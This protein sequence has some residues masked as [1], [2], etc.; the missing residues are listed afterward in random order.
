[1]YAYKDT[2]GYRIC[3]VR[4]GDKVV[5]LTVALAVEAADVGIPRHLML[6]AHQFA[7]A[8]HSERYCKVHVAFF[9]PL[10]RYGAAV[11]SAV[12]C[13]YEQRMPLIRPHDAYR[14]IG[15]DRKYRKH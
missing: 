8:G 6:N 5:V 2:V 11:N 15:K 12:S 9:D 13:V 14:L 10:S 1:M 3:H 7:Q 4:A